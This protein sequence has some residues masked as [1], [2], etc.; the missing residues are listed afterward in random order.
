MREQ[1]TPQEIREARLRLGLTQDQLAHVMGLSSGMAVS[2]WERGIRNAN[3]QA[4]RLLRAYLD[5]YRPENWPVRQQNTEQSGGDTMLPIELV[6]DDEGTLYALSGRHVVKSWAYT[7]STLR[8]VYHEARVFC[9]GWYAAVTVTN[10]SEA[11][12]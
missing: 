3:G 1:M 6:D 7:D 10:N 9:D 12:K 2:D 8:A 11:E 4:R 5:G